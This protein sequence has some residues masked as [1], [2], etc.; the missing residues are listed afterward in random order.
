MSEEDKL[1]ELNRGDQVHIMGIYK[2]KE[3]F[4]VGAIVFHNCIIV[5]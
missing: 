5:N 1:L 2:G 4:Q 3:D